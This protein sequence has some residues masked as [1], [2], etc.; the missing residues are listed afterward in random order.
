MSAVQPRRTQLSDAADTLHHARSAAAR[1]IRSNALTL[2]I[3]GGLVALYVVTRLLLLWRFPPYFDESFYAHE[4]PIALDQPAQRFISLEDSKGP[5]FLWLSFIP[6]KL[7]FAPLTAVRLVSQAGGLWTAGMVGLV[8]RRLSDRVSALVA[9]TVVVVLPLWLVFTSIGFDEPLVAAAAMTALWLQLRL[10]EAPTLRDATLLGVAL[11]AGLLTKQSGE[12]AVLFLP[13]SL[14]VFAWRA[15]DLF[16]RL[17][18][19]VSAAAFAAALGYIFYSVERLS[20]LWYQRQE[21]EKSLG[22]Y[23][24][25][26][27]ALRH[28]GTIFQSNWPGY[29][30]E[31]DD[32][33]TMPMIGAFAVGTGILLA[34]R[35]RLGLLLL[36]WVGVQLAGVVLIASRPL[37]HYLVP[38]LTPAIV[39]MAIGIT[40]TVR[41]ARTWLSGWARTAGIALIVLVAIAPALVFDVRFIADPARDQLP[42][43]DDQ[44]LVT[45]VAAGSGWKEF[46]AIIARRTAGHPA[47][48]VIAYGGLITYDLSLLL[49]DPSATRYPYVPVDYPQAEDAQFVVSTGPL[50]PPCS[51]SLPATAS[52]V[53]APCSLLS[54]HRLVL[55][56]SYQRPRG[57]TRITLYAVQSN[58]PPAP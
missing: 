25:L 2:I 4:A 31:I 44:E 32:Y 33:L 10:V 58:T 26:G 53:G 13:V 1:W 14:L 27:T 54:R 19:W 55:L 21:I 9:M 57:G 7:G 34:R 23:T 15:P 56:R 20:P 8:T 29:R 30:A 39:V 46:A 36:I 17:A 16:V 47:P 37:G 18:V 43:Y 50:P 28:V 49:G 12:F 52:I 38:A 48:H 22:Q 5:L 24:P 45:G 41:G 6:L 40:E 35:V 11:G 51:A 42:S 3:V